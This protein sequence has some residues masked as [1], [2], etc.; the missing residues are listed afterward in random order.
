[1]IS[2]ELFQAPYTDR[3]RSLSQTVE[4]D[5]NVGFVCC[6]VRRH[7]ILPTPSTYNP[8]KTLHDRKGKYL[9]PL[10]ADEGQNLI[11]LSPRTKHDLRND[12]P[13]AFEIL[14]AITGRNPIGWFFLDIVRL[15]G[16]R[17]KDLDLYLHLR[18]TH[19]NDCVSSVDRSAIDFLDVQQL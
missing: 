5:G 17:W 8:N 14:E 11:G 6:Q 2:E 19:V 9:V 1:M 12:E 18:E 16:V 13:V 15:K 7:K 4:L 3:E 10:V